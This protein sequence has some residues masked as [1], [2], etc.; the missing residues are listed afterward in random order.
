MRFEHYETVLRVPLLPLGTER[1]AAG[2]KLYQDGEQVSSF[3]IDGQLFAGAPFAEP[4]VQEGRYIG[5]YRYFADGACTQPLGEGVENSLQTLAP[6]PVDLC[7][8]L[9]SAVQLYANGTPAQVNFYER[10]YGGGFGSEIGCRAGNNGN[11]GYRNLVRRL[12]LPDP[13]V[14]DV[15]VEER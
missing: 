15:P 13:F 2:P 11:V 9:G 4:G 10:S 7:A 6:L 3:W 14:L 5:E 1:Y 8:P 12:T